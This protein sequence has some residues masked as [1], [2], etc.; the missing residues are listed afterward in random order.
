MVVAGDSTVFTMIDKE[1]D[2]ITESFL[3][4]VREFVFL[5][6]RSPEYHFHI[7]L[8]GRNHPFENQKSH[9]RRFIRKNS[10]KSG[11]DRFY[12]SGRTIGDRI[13]TEN[14]SMISKTS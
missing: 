3:W 10:R 11:Y 6:K 4:M 14:S 2:G 1:G 13:R 8:Y 9:R 7:E 5:G 12:G